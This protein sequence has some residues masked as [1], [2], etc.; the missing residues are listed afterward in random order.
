[1]NILNELTAFNKIC[2]EK[3]LRGAESFVLGRQSRREENC[4]LGRI[5]FPQ[6]SPAETSPGSSSVAI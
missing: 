4:L 5:V 6:R 3:R 2:T 1:M